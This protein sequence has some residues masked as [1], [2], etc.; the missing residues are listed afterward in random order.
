[1]FV[2][3]KSHYHKLKKYIEDCS[4]QLQETR[5]VSPG[6]D[7][8]RIFELRKRMMRLLSQDDAYWRQRAKTHW[9]KDGDRNTKKFHA[10]AS[11]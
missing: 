7:Q 2:W 3:K 8:T 6:Q 9:Y 11:A 5:L 10:C 4:K 1:M